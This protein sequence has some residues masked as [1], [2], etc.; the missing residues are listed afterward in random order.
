MA[1][2]D[3]LSKQHMAELS[4]IQPVFTE[5]GYPAQLVAAN[6]E[7]PLSSLVVDLGTDDADRPRFMAVS[8]MPFGDHSFPSTT[9]TQFYVQLPFAFDASQLGDLGHAI[10]LINGAMAV[11]HFAV[12]GDE[13]FFRY[14]LASGSG[15]TV[16][17][18]MLS[19]LVPM[20]IF[21]QEHFADYLEGVLDGEVSLLVLPKLLGS[22]AD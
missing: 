20:L 5:A 10:A 17:S 14:M 4:L 3:S 7:L 18:A 16:D 1:L 13:L 12:R 6:D 21:H 8:I 15:T 22:D 2:P 9:F 11:G 19:E